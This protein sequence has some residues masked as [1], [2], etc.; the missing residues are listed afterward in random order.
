VITKQKP[1]LCFS[2]P[3]ALLISVWRKVRARVPVLAS[4]AARISNS[5]ACQMPTYQA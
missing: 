4:S 1:N 3:I 2:V 5:P